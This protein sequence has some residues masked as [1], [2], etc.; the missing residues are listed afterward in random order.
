[1]RIRRGGAG[2]GGDVLEA[3]NHVLRDLAG[4]PPQS[5]GQIL[6]YLDRAPVLP[7]LG[8]GYLA[9]PCSASPPIVRQRQVDPA[10]S[11]GIAAAAARLARFLGTPSSVAAMGKTQLAEMMSRPSCA[12]AGTKARDGTNWRVANHGDLRGRATIRARRMRPTPTVLP[13]GTTYMSF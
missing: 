13:I 8:Q 9:K 5:K 7:H 3:I 1:M 6:E 2:P 12:S 11:A 4:E 10:L